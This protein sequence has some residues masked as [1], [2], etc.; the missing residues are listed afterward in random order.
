[1][2]A[3]PLL[4]ATGRRR[5]TAEKMRELKGIEGHTIRD[6]GGTCREIRERPLMPC[7]AYIYAAA[8]GG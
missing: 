7:A 8:F 4:H 5:T 6:E 2:S 3:A 1:M